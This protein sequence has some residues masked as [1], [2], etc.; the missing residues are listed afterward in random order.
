MRR[1]DLLI[2]IIRERTR[3]VNFSRDSS[4]GE[5]LEGVSNELILEY[6]NAAQD[7]LQAIVLATYP[8]EFIV[9]KEIPLV[10]DQEEYTIN[11]HVFLNNKLVC[12]EIRSSSDARD[13]YVLDQKSPRE[14]N[15]TKGFPSFYIRRSGKILLNPIPQSTQGM[16]R[17]SYYREVDDLDISRGV[18][19][20][21]ASTS[22]NLDSVT[23]GTGSADSYA[24]GRAEY[25]SICGP[26]GEPKF[27]NIPVE[28]YDSSS[29]VITVHSQYVYNISDNSITGSG[30]TTGDTVTIGKYTTTRS[31][32]PDN[33]ERYLVVYAQKRV[34][35]SDHENNSL[36]EDAELKTLEADILTSF[37][38][39][40][41]DV[42]FIPILDPEIMW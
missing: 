19:T 28:S 40:S 20:D 38:D 5:V 4:T 12:V 41:R 29:G 33:C 3:N 30:V 31:S 2:D 39:E 18:I 25:I 37:A 1:V 14:R 6:L 10:G 15:T 42:K 8:N 32:L 9:Q 27:Y 16:I 36:E 34:L 24:L 13:Y 23:V 22:G 11:D 21:S 35:V 7:H 26:Y 17:P